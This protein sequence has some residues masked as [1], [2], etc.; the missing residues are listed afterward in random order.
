MAGEDQE[1]I[2][3][4][5]WAIELVPGKEYSTTLPYDL[6]I[7]QAVLP[8]SAKDTGRSVVSITFADEKE[9]TISIVSLKLDSNDCQAID[10]ELDEESE[11][12]FTVSGKNPVHLSGYYSPGDEPEGFY[13]DD[14][15]EIDSDEVS[16]DEMGA[17]DS[18][19]DDVDDDVDP[20]TM[21]KV[22]SYLADN[23]RKAQLQNGGAPG[24]KKPKTDAPQQQQQQKATPSKPQQQ[25]AKKPQQQQQQ[26]P[27]QKE[28]Q[29]G[30]KYTILKEGS[31][32]VATKGKSV[33]V[34]YVGTLT[35][36]G[37]K[38]DASTGKPFTFRLGAS[39]VIKGWDLGVAGMKIG[40]KRQL[41]IP[42]E[43]GYGARGAGREI[44]PNSS[45]TFDVELVHVK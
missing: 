9:K 41:I 16:G 12:T 10:V 33:G 32:A 36:N 29:G 3:R 35:K 17:E 21:K 45:L 8:A 26:K 40:E 20:E 31:G 18:D 38:F 30:L 1:D 23:K 43:L 15:E 24:A 11:I 4:A 2:K 25:E 34:R 22:Q 27:Q 19:E 7:T 5:F 13:D 28:L 14:D 42:A 39:E 37:K 44:P 6:H